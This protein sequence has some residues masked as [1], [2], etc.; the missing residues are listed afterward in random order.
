MQCYNARGTIIK[1]IHKSD[2][3]FI[4]GF[5]TLEKSAMQIKVKKFRSDECSPEQF[6]RI[7]DSFDEGA[8]VNLLNA[9]LQSE[10][11][12]TKDQVP[13]K[14]TEGHQ[15]YTPVIIASHLILEGTSF[16]FEHKPVG[17]EPLGADRNP[18]ASQADRQSGT[19]STPVHPTVAAASVQKAAPPP[20]AAPTQPEPPISRS[21]G[22]NGLP[23]IPF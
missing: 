8:V 23:F 12:V 3:L 17:D 9:R 10:K 22:N 18:A 16:A 20:A 14:T 7:C 1:I 15:V 19:R 4:F 13:V 2:N 21:G 11:A 6:V 5:K